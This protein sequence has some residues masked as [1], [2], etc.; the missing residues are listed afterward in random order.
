MI[1]LLIRWCEE[2]LV[3]DLV[4]RARFGPKVSGANLAV[5]FIY[6]GH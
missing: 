4:E 1:D 6:L 2:L 3:R 5:V